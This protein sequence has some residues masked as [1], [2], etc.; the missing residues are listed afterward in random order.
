MRRRTP[1]RRPP[2]RAR[3]ACILRTPSAPRPMTTGASR[4]RDGPSQCSSRELDADRV[5]DL[6][7]AAFEE[8]QQRPRAVPALDELGGE[9]VRLILEGP[10]R[11]DVPGAERRVAEDVPG[12]VRPRVALLVG[13]TGEQEQPLSV[14]AADLRDLE[15]AE[16]ARLRQ[17]RR[18]R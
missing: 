3:A 5:D 9:E 17:R 2:R 6:E 18:Q 4:S 13:V 11:A 8:P 12:A 15:L 16:A 10:R 14:D 7:V 1:P